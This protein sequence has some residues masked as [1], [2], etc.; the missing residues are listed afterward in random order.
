[1]NVHAMV[2][3]FEFSVAQFLQVLH[4]SYILRASNLSFMYSTMHEL[5]KLYVT[6]NANIFSTAD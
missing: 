1:M 2:S 6:Q 3:E 5:G 4:M